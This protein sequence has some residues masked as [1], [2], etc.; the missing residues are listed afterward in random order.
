MAQMLEKIDI[1]L[2]DHCNLNCKGCTHFSPLAE[3]FYLLI[4]H[5]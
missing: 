5:L 3:D 4:F 2:T 1:H